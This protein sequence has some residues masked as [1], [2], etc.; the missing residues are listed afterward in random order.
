MI[1]EKEWVYICDP[2]TCRPLKVR[3]M[4]NEDIP[5]SIDYFREYL[6]SLN[7]NLTPLAGYKRSLTRILIR[8]LETKGV[9]QENGGALCTEDGIIFTYDLDVVPMNG[10]DELN[11]EMRKKCGHRGSCPVCRETLPSIPTKTNRDR[12]RNMSDAELGEWLD[13]ALGPCAPNSA[14][15]DSQD[16]CA[17][18]WKIWLGQAVKE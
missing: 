7:G 1:Q 13:N 2:A 6:Y 8:N 15:E 12:L 14:C 17:K 3:K 9:P 10:V 5:K 18:C 16:D 11:S 4:Q